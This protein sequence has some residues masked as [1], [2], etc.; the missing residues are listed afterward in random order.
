MKNPATAK[1]VY[2]I[3][4][5]EGAAANNSG[6]EYDT[7]FLA[8]AYNNNTAY[9]ISEAH[10]HQ[11]PQHEFGRV[12]I[13]GE[14]VY[15]LHHNDLGAIVSSM[16]LQ[17]AKR[18]R[19]S[20]DAG[21][22]SKSNIDLILS[23][24]RAVETARSL[25]LVVLP[26]RF[27]SILTHENVKKLLTQQYNGLK[28]KAF[29][30]NGKDEYGIRLLLGEKTEE[31]VIRENV[32][33]MPDI[34]RLRADILSQKSSGR[35]G[36]AYFASLRLNDMIKNKTLKDIDG[37]AGRIHQ[38]VMS[39]AEATSALSKDTSRT[40]FNRAYLVKRSRVQDLNRVID[41][42]NSNYS[43]K[44]DLVLHTSGPWAPYSFCADDPLL[45]SF[46]KSQLAT[47]ADDPRRH[48][49]GGGSGRR[50]LKEKVGGSVAS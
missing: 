18:I 20:I 1:Y 28:M 9:H 38:K 6:G 12:G 42:I 50:S 14:R 3:F 23:H 16:S 29:R 13:N 47:T 27:G 43:S 31:K 21:G 34:Q 49:G 10:A 44:Y 11:Q 22:D 19:N 46:T 41:D 30:F 4:W 15:A 24:Q 35:Q 17:E 40:I 7:A 39:V 8:G 32:E 33:H 26:V 48:H 2:G 25:G 5:D 37:L 36:T 45:S